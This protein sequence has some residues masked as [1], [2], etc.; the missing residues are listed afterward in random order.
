MRELAAVHDDVASLAAVLRCAA[1][2]LPA[3]EGHAHTA[4]LVVA[5]DAVVEVYPAS[6]CHD[7]A[8]ARGVACVGLARQLVVQEEAVVHLQRAVVQI[9]GRAAVVASARVHAVANGDTGNCGLGKQLVVARFLAD[10]HKRLLAIVT[11]AVAVEVGAPHRLSVG[12]IADSG[13]GARHRGGIA[14]LDGHSGG[15]L[16]IAEVH[17]GQVAALHQIDGIALAQ[18]LNRGTQ[19]VARCRVLPRRAVH[20][21]STLGAEEILVGHHCLRHGQ[22]D[23]HHHRSKNFLHSRNVLKVIDFPILKYRC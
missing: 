7:D 11:L 21:P 5:P 22:K 17:V 2:R 10:D 6:A 20:L 18:F 1:A 12:G 4:R 16:P 8:A 15:N 23:R 19:Q 14:A 3:L 9:H 13:V